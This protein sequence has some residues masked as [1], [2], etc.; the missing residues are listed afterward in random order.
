MTDDLTTSYLT[1]RKAQETRAFY[2][3]H[4]ARLALPT[5]EEEA[6][7]DLPLGGVTAPLEAGLQALGEKAKEGAKAAEP[8]LDTLAKALGLELPKG[9][10]SRA[11]EF[12]TGA[13]SPTMTPGEAGL[14]TV[15]SALPLAGTLRAGKE[16]LRLEHY[17]PKRGLTLLDPQYAGTGR[18]GAEAKRGGLP[19]AYTYLEGTKPEPQFAGLPKYTLEVPRERIAEGERY[20]EFVKQYPN[21]DEREAALKAAGYLGYRD[22]TLG[23]P[24]GNIVALF[25]PVPMAHAP[26]PPRPLP[27]RLQRE[28]V[29][30]STT[31]LYETGGSTVSPVHGNLRGVNGYA[32]AVMPE[33]RQYV[34]GMAAPHEFEAWLQETATKLDLLD[35]SLA[36]GTWFD[37]EKNVT[38]F[39]LSLVFDT[40]DDALDFA[41]KTGERAIY[42]LGT[43]QEIAT[44]VTKAPAEAGRASI[45]SVLALAGALAGGAYGWSA[46]DP[47]ADNRVLEALKGAGLGAL[48]GA[49]LPLAHSLARRMGRAPA[50]TS[51]LTKEHRATPLEE[52]A[53]QYTERVA[54]YRRGHIS[55]AASRAAGAEKLAAGELSDEWLATRYPGTAYNEAELAAIR[56]ILVQEGVKLRQ[57]AQAYNR[58]PGNE[59]LEREFI[60]QFA[61]YAAL[62]PLFIGAK[63][64]AGRSLSFLNDLK[65]TANV[66]TSRLSGILTKTT[67]VRNP[68]RA[69][70][71]IA[72]MPSLD[73]LA[74]FVRHATAPGLGEMFTE[75]W[76]NGLLSQ[77]ITHTTNL[78]SGA[79]N[80]LTSIPERAAASLFHSTEGVARGE[81]TA[82]VRG[83][84]DAVGRAWVAAAR[85]F[86]EDRPLLGRAK[87]ETRSQAI[88]A[89]NVNL[90]LERAGLAPLQGAWVKGIDYLGTA[91][92]VPSRL[93]LAG[94]EFVKW[95]AYEGELSALAWRA[96]LREGEAQGLKGKDLWAFTRDR[97][98]RLLADPTTREAFHEEATQFANYLT[99][100]KEL[101]EA[102][103]A[104]QQVAATPLGRVVLPF[105]RTPINIAKYA[106]ERTPFALLARTFWRDIQAGGATRDL[107][108]ARLGLGS[109]TMAL[110]G[111]LAAS[112]VITGFG[113]QEK[114]TRQIWTTDGRR[115]YSVNVTALAR[116]MRGDDP[117][118][119]TGDT[120]VAYNRID[121]LGMLIGLAADYTDILLQLEDPTVRDELATRLTLVASHVL[122][123]KTYVKGLADWLL[124]LT[125]PE[126][127]GEKLQESFARTLVTAVPVVGPAAKLAQ[128][129]TDPVLRDADGALNA[130][131]ATLPGYS[132]DLPPRIN[133]WGETVYREGWMLESA[134][135]PLYRSTHTKDPVVE[136]L[137]EANVHL[138]QPRDTLGN[139]KLTPQQYEFLLRR[140]GDVK[141]PGGRTLYEQYQHLLNLLWDRT[142]PALR[143]D[144]ESLLH[145]ALKEAESAYKKLARAELLKQ[146]PELRS[147]LLEDYKSRAAKRRP[148]PVDETNIRI[149]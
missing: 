50:P 76:I 86:R 96:A 48:A 29:R 43:G 130:I 121:P 83:Y 92:R 135:S 122:A 10:A 110:I 94:D 36:L 9:G 49:A 146:Y 107:A 123:S 104:I 11:L 106:G 133:Y 62:D 105:V 15:L 91:A 118:P 16:V 125:D 71:L 2:R 44:G 116:L 63:T 126:H 25:E 113:P 80:L 38:E 103:Q 149:Q 23:K 99:F 14:A 67:A 140:F 77:P 60:H 53:K 95:V 55:H 1:Y 75:A 148:Q 27:H 37:R 68:K 33:L 56:E 120:W 6:L 119:Q 12:V 24:Y 61:T 144:P 78:I 73:G 97:H 112:G 4:A 84:L 82:L 47:E 136:K 139:L 28:L 51:P 58:E 54:Q 114:E 26:R 64:E 34:P 93:I 100:A 8:Y 145:L 101:G 127:Y 57:L 102:G 108:L 66:F 72:A 52:I 65:D 89:E 79:L 18:A 20:Q 111:T 81:A 147:A 74:T 13:P 46:A 42:S 3:D 129:I 132:K 30:T 32:V 69:A 21:P 35:D 31:D 41:R 5:P 88:T 131:K 109:G 17:S 124:A 19:K 85:A 137:V 90:L 115:P 141:G 7:Q 117:S 40:L 134:L 138:T 45:P 143:R 39:S 142:P 22:E 87:L 128:R 98:Q 59:A 70:E